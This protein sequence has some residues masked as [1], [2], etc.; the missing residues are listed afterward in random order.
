MLFADMVGFSRLNEED[1]PSFLVHFLGAIAEMLQHCGAPPSFVNTWG[2]GLF[3]VFD[4]VE[5][6]VEFALRLRDAVLDTDWPARGLPAGTS[7]RIGMH[8]GP[9]FE[10]PDPLIGRAN[11]FGS[12]VVRAARIEPVAVPGA[13]YVSAELA[14]QLAAS[15]ANQFATDY[16]GV[17]PLA[18]SYG[19]GPLYRLRRAE[20][21][22]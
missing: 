4:E 5:T 12:H 8:T 1:T 22:E 2:D 6:G 16:L 15:G 14:Y 9:V 13:V 21:A 17:L 10:A 18:K 3:M 11:Y 20:E 7:L 19:T